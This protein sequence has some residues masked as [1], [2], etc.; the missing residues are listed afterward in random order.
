LLGF[1]RV[2]KGVH[3]KAKVLLVVLIEQPIYVSLK[4]A[5]ENMF[6]VKASLSTEL[7]RNSALIFIDVV[8]IVFPH[9]HGSNLP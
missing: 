2:D 1:D 3:L 7:A 9:T 6:P 8:V 4:T 5:D